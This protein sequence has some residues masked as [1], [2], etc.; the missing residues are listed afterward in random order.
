MKNQK[1]DGYY[2]NQHCRIDADAI[3]TLPLAASRQRIPM[4]ENSR[5]FGDLTMTMKAVESLNAY[6][7]ITLG[8][9]LQD[10][11]ESP[12][13]WS[14]AGVMRIDDSG[15][16]RTLIYKKLDLAQM[17][18]EK[19][20]SSHKHNRQTIF[21]SISRWYRAELMYQY[22]NESVIHTRY[23]FEFKENVD[24]E[25]MCREVDIVVNQNFFDLCLKEGL[26]FN[27]RRLVG[28]GD[29]FYAVQIDAYL[30]SN[31]VKIKNGYAYRSTIKEETLFKVLGLDKTHMKQYTKR[32][33]IKRAFAAI[34]KAG[35]PKYLLDA[36]NKR[37]VRESAIKGLEVK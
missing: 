5:K 7:L 3:H 8:Q 11:Q 14:D 1:E 31:K 15:A 25:G 18:K 35:L 36:E 2:K 21:E 9:L 30:Q 13:S 23:V 32:A 26:V 34:E 16:E 29:K 22:D 20:L 28:Y 33:K 6:D 4:Y 24:A 37:W 17:A 27:W 19:G 12:E 10:Y